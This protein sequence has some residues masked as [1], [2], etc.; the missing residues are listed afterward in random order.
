MGWGPTF[1]PVGIK[2]KHPKCCEVA[3]FR[4]H[5]GKLTWTPKMEVWKMIFLFKG[6]IFRFHVSF[7]RSTWII[8][9]LPA[10]PPYHY[11]TSQPRWSSNPAASQIAVWLTPKMQVMCMY[12]NDSH[13]IHVWLPTFGCFYWQ[14]MVNVGKYVYIYIPYMDA[15]RL[16]C[17]LCVCVK[18][19]LWM[20]ETYMYRINVW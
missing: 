4:I 16:R 8:N 3:F 20:N 7:R 9:G 10:G 17:N 5:P 2:E 1:T 6:V 19:R 13:T 18:A 15:M 14:N 11:H 12:G